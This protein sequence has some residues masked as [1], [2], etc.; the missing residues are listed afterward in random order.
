MNILLIL[1]GVFI[2]FSLTVVIFYL[3]RDRLF[4]PKIDSTSL[5]E[6]KLNEIFP[7]VLEN[8]NAQLITMAD[9]KLDA[10]KQT[11]D[12]DMANKITAI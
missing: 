5:I 6:Q 10:K 7:K 12:M 1:L 11:I 4:G 9:Q 3:F 8:A 2:G